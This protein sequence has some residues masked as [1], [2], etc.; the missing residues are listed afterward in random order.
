MAKTRRTRKAGVLYDPNSLLKK[1]RLCTDEAAFL[2]DVSAR[3]VERYMT[4]GKLE[5]QR[6]PGGHRRPLT[7][8]VRK[9]L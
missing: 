9:Y 3:T 1:A 5:F 6:T 2:L 7:A 4:E 8:S